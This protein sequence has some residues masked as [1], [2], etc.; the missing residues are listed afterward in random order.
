[1]QTGVLALVMYY[2][3]GVIGFILFPELFQFE[4]V[5]QIDFARMG[6]CKHWTRSCITVKRL[7][8][9]GGHCG[10]AEA[11]AEQ[12]WSTLHFYLEMHPGG[13]RHGVAQRRYWRGH[14]GDP[15]FEPGCLLKYCCCLLEGVC[16]QAAPS[17]TGFSDDVNLW[18]RWRMSGQLM[19][20]LKQMLLC[21][22]CLLVAVEHFSR[23]AR[24]LQDL[25]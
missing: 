17:V 20:G 4:K 22:R 15:G 23:W 2:V 13:S 6:H 10:R 19:R 16:Q 9:S 5:K 12:Q 21:L 25:L 1:M 11:R 7:L 8:R 24:P 14:A 3:F 18:L